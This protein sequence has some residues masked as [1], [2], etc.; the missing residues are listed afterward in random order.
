MRTLTV[1]EVDAV[2]G[3]V[4]PAVATF[5]LGALQGGVSSH[6]AG[7]SPAQIAASALAGGASAT[8]A[9]IAA[10]KALCAGERLMVA[11]ASMGY[12]GAQVL[13]GK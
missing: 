3:G 7:G 9:G 6:M 4:A 10:I 8:F 13:V 5:G 12:F 1:D 11:T 2:S